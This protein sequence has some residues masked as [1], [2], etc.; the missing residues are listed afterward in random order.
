MDQ[1]QL[2]Q[3][4]AKAKEAGFEGKPLIV[5]RYENKNLALLGDQEEDIRRGALA[6]KI[7]DQ[8]K[9]SPDIGP[10][11]FKQNFKKVEK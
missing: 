2:D 6:L 1:K 3:I 5:E 10:V 4:E 11:Y 8:W 9:I 7:G